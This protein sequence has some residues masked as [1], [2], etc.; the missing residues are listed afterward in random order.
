MSDG[1]FVDFPARRRILS[2]Q[3]VDAEGSVCIR[4]DFANGETRTFK[5]RDDML[6]RF[7]AEGAE[8]ML[9][10]SASVAQDMQAVVSAV[11]HRIA[12]LNQGQWR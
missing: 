7:A 2:S 12:R 10:T 1:R 4:L 8:H 6:L 3:Y 11:D 9:R 5:V